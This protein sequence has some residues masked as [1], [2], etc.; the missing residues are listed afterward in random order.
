MTFDIA[1]TGINAASA[2]L[3]VISNNIANSATTGFKRSRA[4]FADVYALSTFGATNPAT[5]Q[6]VR[7]AGIRQEF[8]QGDTTFTNNNLDMSIEGQGLFRLTDNGKSLY[9]RAGNFGLDRE[10]YIVSTSGHRLTGYGTS[11]TGEVLPIVEDPCGNILMLPA[12]RR[13]NRTL[14]SMLNS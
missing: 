1:L 12:M 13:A 9:T 4:E 3:D 5:G 2:E 14:L 7:V 11:D 10:G 6:G 8:A